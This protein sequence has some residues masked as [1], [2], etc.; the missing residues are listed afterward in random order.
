[1]PERSRRAVGSLARAVRDQGGRA[2]VVGGAVRDAVWDD[3][4]GTRTI[5][6]DVDLEVFGI[7]AAQLRRMLLAA[8]P[9]TKAVGEAFGVLTVEGLGL[10][11]SVPRTERK[12]TPGHRGFD[13]DV[14]H[15][16]TPEQAAQRRDF[17]IN[18]ISWDPL[19]DEVIDPTGGIADLDARRLRHV[20][21]QFGEDPLR[22]LRGAQFVARFGLTAD[23][24]TIALC[25]GL[26]SEASTLARERV[27]DEVTKLLMK[28]TEPGRGLWFAHDAGWIDV[29]SPQLAALRGVEQDPTWHPEGDVFT[30]T[31]HVL[32]YVA[33]HLRSG[34][35]CDDLAVAL[36]C[37]AHDF[38]KAGT[39]T[40]SDGR[41][42]AHGHDEAGVD[43]T[44]QW[45]A[46]FAGK[47]VDRS[48][49]TKVVVEL[50]AHH[51]APAMLHAQG[52]SDR[53]VR[54]LATKVSRI[55]LL[56]RV[57]EADAGGRPPKVLDG[58]PAGEWLLDRAANLS[59]TRGGPEPL[60]RGQDLIDE[61]GL[62]PGPRFGAVLGQVLDAQV[63]GDVTSRAEAL[64]LARVITA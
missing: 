63:E 8:H 32:D 18:A 61:L 21:P 29:V 31:A 44:R 1:M 46:D 64:A 33:R 20:G 55:D 56:V 40:F 35:H 27:W 37:T 41:W 23:P 22:V 52:S 57:A 5:A 26:R 9:D 7:P 17:T 59:V 62:E 24:G 39:T 42:R 34:D 3:R 25:A 45:L 43:P 14:D 19:T 50:V 28:G 54:R 48:A 12:T 10:D 2:L 36:A 15:T 38:G 13:V 16:L 6:K 60:L 51:L 49:L 4:R 11:V 30:H 53:S 47:G 58:F